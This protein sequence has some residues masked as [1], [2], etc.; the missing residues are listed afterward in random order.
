M[1]IHTSRREGAL[2]VPPGLAEEELLL[3]ELET[4]PGIAPVDRRTALIAALA[5]V[6]AVGMISRSDLLSAHAG[7]LDAGGR[8]KGRVKL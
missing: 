5:I 2:P 6:I 4:P 3:P 8:K 1:D 7:R